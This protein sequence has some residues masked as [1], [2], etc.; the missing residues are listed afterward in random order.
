MDVQQDFR[1]VLEL[2]NK[3]KVDYILVGAYALGFDGA[4][5]GTP[6]TLASIVRPDPINIKKHNASPS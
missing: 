6:A 2:F 1:D 5:P 4:P 3:H